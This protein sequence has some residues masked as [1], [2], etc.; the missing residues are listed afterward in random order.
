MAQDMT[1]L[2]TMSRGELDR[3]GVVARVA[4]G[5]LTQAHAAELLRLS[6]RQVRR[7]CR[8]RLRH[9]MRRVMLTDADSSGWTG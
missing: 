3:A 5:R 1:A 8:H 2:V 4:E 6:V 9:A 7:L